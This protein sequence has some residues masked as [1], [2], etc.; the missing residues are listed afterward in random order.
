ML[1]N[2]SQRKCLKSKEEEKS[3]EED[4]HELE[5]EGEK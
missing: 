4:E 2:D 5:H 1:D 3:A